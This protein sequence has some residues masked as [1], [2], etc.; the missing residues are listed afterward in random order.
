MP[1]NFCP[2]SSL[3]MLVMWFIAPKSCHHLVFHDHFPL[4]NWPLENCCQYSESQWSRLCWAAFLFLHSLSI[5]LM[6]TLFSPPELTRSTWAQM[7]K[8]SRCP[9]LL[10]PSSALASH[11]TPV[12]S[13]RSVMERWCA[14]WPSAPP[15][16]TSTPA[17]KAVWKCGTS[18]NQAARVRWPNWTVWWDLRHVKLVVG[19]R[20]PS[21]IGIR[22]P[23]KM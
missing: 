4:S 1:F 13:T 16:V 8:C 2:S 6:S 11:V 22:I 18:A 12:R 19:A 3:I 14:R 15:R 20:Q 7:V 10:T 17:G 21:W 9:S 23:N 5:T